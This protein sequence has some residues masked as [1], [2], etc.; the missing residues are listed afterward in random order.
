MMT[1]T[2]IIQ[3]KTQYQFIPFFE[4]FFEGIATTI[5]SF[6]AEVSAKIDPEPTD[7]W[8]VQAYFEK[9][10]NFT[11]IKAQLEE[12][13]G[14]NQ[15][16]IIS[17]E[18]DIIENVDFAQKV[19]DDFNPIRVGNFYI[20]NSAHKTNLPQELISMEISSG[21][22][23]GTG[24]H[25]TTSGC[26]EC[27][28]EL[29]EKPKAILDMGTGSGVLSIAAAKLFNCSVIASDIEENSI[30]TAS[31]N[32]KINHV[33]DKIK[34]FL[35]DGYDQEIYDSGPY[36][37]ILSNILARPLISMASDLANNLKNGGVA[38]LAGFLTAQAEQVIQAHL[39]QGLKLSH[40]KNKNNWVIAQL[41]K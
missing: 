15:L 13:A 12:Y 17:L 30:I 6:E 36:D 14:S 18:E 3:A 23:F 22:A 38:I 10:P 34:L 35:A 9:Q 40:T 25:E 24:D 41:T 7:I 19:L 37:L 21:L 11:D 28:S 1:K 8:L 29:K 39:S 27:L 33:A 20:H 31:D 26:L 2:F 16:L 4:A 32:F 5:S